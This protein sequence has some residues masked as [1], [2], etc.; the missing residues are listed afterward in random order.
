MTKVG[1]EERYVKRSVV[2]HPLAHKCI[3]NLRSIVLEKGIDLSYS[4]A[5][6]AFVIGQVCMTSYDRDEGLRI[7]WDFMRDEK[8]I[9]E[10]NEKD[11]MEQWKEKMRK[12]LVEILV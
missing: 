8:T 5:I 12:K 9:K 1:K 7:M 6:N 2:I 10:I 3:Q 4:A 11:A